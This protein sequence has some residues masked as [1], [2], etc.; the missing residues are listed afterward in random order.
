MDRHKPRVCIIGAGT[1]G[2]I[3]A[4]V[5]QDRGLDF[6]CFEQGSQ[7]GGLWRFGNDNG[8]NRIYRSLHINTSKRMMQLSDY[9]FPDDVPEYPGNADV[10][11]YFEDYASHFE[12]TSR[13]TFNSSVQQVERVADGRWQVTVSGPDGAYSRNYDAVLVASGHHW[14][15][16][17]VELAGQFSGVQLHAHDYCS[18][19]EPYDLTAKRVVVVGAGNSAMDIACE[20]GQA[21]RE[22]RG[23]SR[24]ILSQRSGVWITPKL[25]GNVAQD[26][27]LRHPMRRPGVLEHS[28]RSL[29]PQRLRTFFYNAFAETWLRV[30][31]GDPRRVGLKQPTCRYSE[32]HATVSQDIHT[33]L[34]HG[35]IVPRG[36]IRELRGDK[37]I[38]EDGSTETADVLVHCTGYNISFPF[39][40]PSLIAFSD[41]DI[42]L[43]QRI[44]DPRYD[45]LMF[46]ALVQPVC[47]MMPIAELQAEFVAAYLNDEYQLPA[48]EQMARDC[49]AFHQAMKST[50]T[51]SPSHT[52][53]I[54]CE[55]YS[56]QLYR[57]WD[58]GRR[59]TGKAA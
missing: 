42:A 18:V 56:Y 23:P 52:I 57:E 8:L 51:A 34:I 13:I 39:F 45:N 35:D 20:L 28:R 4:K 22:E 24:V 31:V 50:F 32:R 55:E 54:D 3:T 10:I 30:V 12:L 26:K 37:V 41:N 14:D 47:S 46:M 9:P 15:P 48:R 33:R 1:T 38:F 29:L 16:R 5:L 25:K 21:H 36:E 19:T 27:T 11:R 44:F 53:E 58:R 6:D 49:A 17:R 43:W 59:R 7:I 40:D 2:V